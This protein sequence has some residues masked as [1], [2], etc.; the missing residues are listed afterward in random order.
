MHFLFAASAAFA[1]PSSLLQFFSGKDRSPFSNVTFNGTTGTPLFQ[2]A[3]TRARIDPWSG[4]NNAAKAAGKLY[5]GSAVDTCAFVDK[6]YMR[7]LNNTKDFGQITPSNAMKVRYRQ[8]PAPLHGIPLA[9]IKA[10]F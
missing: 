2:G 3:N 4:L 9:S 7:V 10:E 5:L 1:G 8:L 6:N